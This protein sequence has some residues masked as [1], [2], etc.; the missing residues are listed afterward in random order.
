MQ[1]IIPTDLKYFFQGP[2]FV[3]IIVGFSFGQVYRAIGAKSRNWRMSVI[4]LYFLI[5][6]FLVKGQPYVVRA[7]NNI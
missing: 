3:R 1:A 4:F 6:P 2:G 5:L 7:K